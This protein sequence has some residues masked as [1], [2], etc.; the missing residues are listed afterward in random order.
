M[1]IYSYRIAGF[2]AIGAAMC[3]MQ[4]CAPYFHQPTA[5]GKA[6]LGEETAFTADLRNLPPAREKIVAAVY[7]FRDQTGQYKQSETGTSFST[8][9]SQGTTNILLKAL[10]ESNWFTPIERENVANLLNERKIVRSSVAQYKEGENLP[11]LL[12]AGIILEGGIISY[13]ANII[14]GGGGLRYFAAGGSTQYRQ[15]RVT[16]Y[17]RAVATRSGKILKT[18]YTSKTILSQSIDGGLFRYVT[19]KRLLEAETGFSTNEPAQMA[20]TEAIEK[21]VQSLIMEGVRDNLWAPAEKS[22]AQMKNL[23]TAYE[24]EKTQMSDVDVY[25]VKRSAID[26][27]FVTIQPQV[28]ATRLY[29]DFARRSVQAGYGLALDFHLTPKIGLQA[30]VGTGRFLNP[31]QFNQ[32]Y[33]SADINLLFKPLPFQRITPVFVLGGGVVASQLN[34]SP[35]SLAGRRFAKLNGGVGLQFMTSRA[36]GVRAMVDYNQLLNDQLDGRTA[37][38]FNDY[39]LRG[40]LGLTFHL[41]RFNRTQPVKKP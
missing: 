24:Q 30:A 6:R 11:P 25:G 10:E 9:I 3:L 4:S 5:P 19:F 28:T 22:A 33:S 39:Y 31:D 18:V 2:L 20:V 27:P 21:A 23:V 17:L 41:G 14:T 26:A 40:T 34:G 15:D 32:A 7:K 29:S 35:F 12:F 36:L 8:A 13:D 1:K 38:Q 37:G 16:V